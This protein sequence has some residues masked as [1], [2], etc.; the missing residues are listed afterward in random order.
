MI[1]T[2]GYAKNYDKLLREAAA[3]GTKVRKLGESKNYPGGYAFKTAVDGWRRIEEMGYKGYAVYAVDADWKEHTA[4]S[5]LREGTQYVGKPIEGWWNRLLV[6][7]PILYR[8]H[9]PRNWRKLLVKAI[10]AL[11]PEEGDPD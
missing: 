6:S 1:Y 4:P 3:K 7:R 8:V 10:A 9:K 2:I 5:I 11:P